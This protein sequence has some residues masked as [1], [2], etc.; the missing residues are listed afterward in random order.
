MEDR[1]G[2]GKEREKRRSILGEREDSDEEN[3]LY[4]GTSCVSSHSSEA[5]C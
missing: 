3:G 5:V 2:K 4:M 1:K